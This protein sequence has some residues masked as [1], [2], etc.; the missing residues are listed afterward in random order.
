MLVMG[1]VELVAL[2]SEHAVVGITTAIFFMAYA[3][4]LALAARGLAR[5]RS[6]ARAPL[7]LAQL[8]Q[9]GLAWSFRGGGTTWVVVLLAVPACFVAVV[10]LMPTTTEALYGGSRDDEPAG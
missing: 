2:D 9:L 4:G 10:L 7:L 8:I 1:V 3:V 5:A 6:W